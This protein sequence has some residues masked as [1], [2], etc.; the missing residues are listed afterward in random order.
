MNH[1]NSPDPSK[2][3]IDMERIERARGRSGLARSVGVLLAAFTLGGCAT[4]RTVPGDAAPASAELRV[5]FSSPRDLVVYTLSGDSTNVANVAQLRGRV[6]E[7]SEDMIT[8]EP[9]RTL[10]EGSKVWQRYGDGAVVKIP[11]Q[12]V[13]VRKA[14]GGR[15]L[16][17]MLALGTLLTV[18]VAA[19][20]YE[21]PPPPP[22]DG[23]KYGA[24]PG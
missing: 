1:S 22:K 19:A 15:T 16:L 5:R 9:S 6:V 3:E 23:S 4:Y 18:I 12:V 14:S 8:I 11:M 7:R 17:L 2:E 24:G 10:P 21:E 13:E 20:T